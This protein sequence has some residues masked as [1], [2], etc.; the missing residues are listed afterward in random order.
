[1]T[2]IE[3]KNN[4][5]VTLLTLITKSD[6]LIKLTSRSNDLLP[7]GL[8]CFNFFYERLRY[9]F[10]GSGKDLV[11][12]FFQA[13]ALLVH[14]LKDLETFINDIEVCFLL[15]SSFSEFKDENDLLLVVC[16]I[17]HCPE[18]LLQCLKVLIEPLSFSADRA[19]P[20]ASRSLNRHSA[21]GWSW[22]YLRV[23]I[24]RIELINFVMDR[25]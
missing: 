22:C 13:W 15:K 17:L 6:E 4:L 25:V 2:L 9:V 18:L 24:D 12:S 5:I 14:F 7:N 16:H 23:F 1:M 20:A 10:F 11:H 21:I 8:S 3:I 19:T